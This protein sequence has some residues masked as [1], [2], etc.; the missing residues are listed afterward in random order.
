MGEATNEST[1]LGGKELQNVLQLIEAPFA[2]AN[3]FEW[4]I[5]REELLF[6]VVLPF[7][8]IRPIG[9]EEDINRLLV[10]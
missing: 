2:F 9:L 7:L 5:S 3:L 4:R 6:P 10:N 8:F 1:K